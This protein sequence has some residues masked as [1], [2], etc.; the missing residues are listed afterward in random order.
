MGIGAWELLLVFVVALLVFGPRKIPELA[1]GLG[2]GLHELRRLS[3]E[4]QREIHLADV[5]DE[6]K[7]IA[8]Q[9][10]PPPPADSGRPEPPG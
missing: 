1:R 10:A 6:R 8:A 9:A 2:K 4:L 5:E 7:R 3:T